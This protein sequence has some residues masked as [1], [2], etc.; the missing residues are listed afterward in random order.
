M[1]RHFQRVALDFAL[2]AVIVGSSEFVRQVDAALQWMESVAPEWHNYVIGGMDNLFE[3][4][5]SDPGQCLAFAYSK[6][7][8]VYLESCFINGFQKKGLSA[9]LDQL[10]IAIFLAIGD[11]EAILDV[12]RLRDQYHEFH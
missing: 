4:T 9:R 11:R 10:E 2:Q 8:H 7:R 12:G 1:Q 5:D 3:F 6:Q